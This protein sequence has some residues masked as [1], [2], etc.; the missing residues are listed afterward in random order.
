MARAA[1]TPGWGPG[2]EGRKDNTSPFDRLRRA[3]FTATGV[4]PRRWTY[5]AAEQGAAGDGTEQRQTLGLKLLPSPGSSA[6]RLIGGAGV[7]PRSAGVFQPAA[8]G[9]DNS[10]AAAALEGGGGTGGAGGAAEDS[11]GAGDS[12]SS[13]GGGRSSGG[14][15]GNNQPP[16]LA[17]MV[18]WFN[19]QK[20]HVDKHLELYSPHASAPNGWDVLWFPVPAYSCLVPYGGYKLA[21]KILGLL[22]LLLV[23]PRPLVLHLISG[24]AY[25]FACC[26]DLMRHLPHGGPLPASLGLANAS[27]SANTYEAIRANLRG[28]VYDSPVGVPGIGNAVCGVVGISASSLLG[29]ALK[30][31]LNVYY[32]C[33]YPITI[34]ALVRVYFIYRHQ[35]YLFPGVRMLFV[36]SDDD[37]VA[38]VD[39]CRT[40]VRS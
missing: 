40:I 36:Y 9:D 28:I 33:T 38:G 15:G 39:L 14:G 21:E 6:A 32:A 2:D 11:A 5:T 24:G 29:A 18:G 30:A 34:G 25:I 8:M 10:A 31:V 23:H 4:W 1:P 26:C 13:S 22:E 17:V 16:P 3:W 12:G 20:R 35:D 19:A 7:I 37:L 27:P